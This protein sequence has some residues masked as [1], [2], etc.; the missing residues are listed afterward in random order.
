MICG[1]GVGLCGPAHLQKYE[2]CCDKSNIAL[3]MCKDGYDGD[4]SLIGG[5]GLV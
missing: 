4:V 1:G 5:A 2:V 3:C